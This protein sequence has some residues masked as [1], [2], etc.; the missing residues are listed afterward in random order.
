MIAAKQQAAVHFGVQG[1]H[2]PAEHLWPAG[3]IGNVADGDASFAQEL[4]CAASGKNFYAQRREPFR[5]VHDPSFVENTDERA[6]H[7]HVISS[8]GKAQQ[9]KRLVRNVKEET[10]LDWRVEEKSEGRGQHAAPLQT[11]LMS[12]FD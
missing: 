4:G 1:L 8:A 5:E 10:R 12:G 3:E 6:L 2:A 9:C 7:R 11:E